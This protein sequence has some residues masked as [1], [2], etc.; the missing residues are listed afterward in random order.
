[1]SEL[2][3]QG[4]PAYSTVQISGKP[5]SVLIFAFRIPYLPDYLVDHTL[6]GETEQIK[7]KEV[8]N[9]F[10]RFV[11]SLRKYRNSAYSLRYSSDPD[12]GTIDVHLVCRFLVQPGSEIGAVEQY[13]QDISALLTSH[14]LPH[15]LIRDDSPAT[16]QKILVPSQG[17]NA[18]VE[19]RQHEAIVPLLS[20]DK[21]AYVIHPFWAASGEML[22]PFEVMLRQKK[23]VTLGIYLEP[24]ELAP[25]EQA[26]LSEAAYIAQTVSD[27]EAP[28]QS[29][30][31]I[32]RR[33]DPGAELVGRIYTEYLNSLEE[34]FVI[35]TQVIGHDPNA[36]WTVA[37]SFISSA[38]DKQRYDR[39]FA[40]N[41]SLPSNA[42]LWTPSDQLEYQKALSTFTNL[43]WIPWGSSKASA[44]K[45]RLPYLSGV[46]GA[47]AVFRF[48][49]S[50]RGGVP[51]IPVKQMAP[52]FEPGHR[53]AESSG[54][55][56][57]IGHLRRGGKAVVP[58]KALTRHALITGFTGSGKTNT[59]LFIL[60]QLW[61]KHK[62]PFL[63]IEAAKKEYRALSNVEGFKDLL[64]FTLGDETTSPFRHNPFELLEGIRLES[65][66]GRLQSCF[67]AAL[68][69]FGILPSIIGEAMEEIYKSKGW[70]LTDR[71]EHGDERLFP[72]MR[73]MFTAVI[74]IAENRGYAGETYH[75][76]RAAAAGRIGSLLRGS[77]GRM[78]GCQKSIPA[79][80][81]FT[82]PV[83]LELNDLNEDDKA[84][85]MMFLLT[86]MREYRET[87]PS[88][89]IQH[90]TV[91]EEAHNVL[92][93][94]QSVGNTEV[95]A[96]TK[97]K[98]V[99]SFSNIL[100]EV[101]A[102]GEG[103]LIADQSPEKLAPDAMRN[104]N[105]QIAHQL[106][107]QRDREAIARAMIMNDVQ[108]EF[109]AKLR[110]GEAALFQ[111]G[112]ERATFIMVPEF[113]DSAGFNK[114]PSDTDI[115]SFM[116]PF[117]EKFSKASLPFYGCR[118]CSA[119][120]I[121]RES[122]EPSTF[123]KERHEDLLSSLLEFENHP[124][125]E[126]WPKNW[127]SLT[128]VCAGASESVGY[129]GNLDAAYCFLA[130][131]IDFQ[132]TEHMRKM[133]EKTFNE[134]SKEG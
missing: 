111:T 90:L 105:L 32:R 19:I 73:D 51:G 117:Q 133:F 4:K 97:A 72:T 27:L 65:H 10:I 66:L 93:N 8:L 95:A 101:R 124:E 103:I 78:F 118:F 56:I 58:I 34:P 30:T 122:V 120:C 28:V 87:H 1:M 44:H 108:R 91:V 59:L 104:T 94:A 98:A 67:D 110:V 84:L 52:D 42:D 29:S 121:Y 24:T 41:Q 14:N 125:P 35:V 49:I 109:L 100:S 134:V 106:R 129:K 79:D 115:R 37:K 40:R 2:S 77:K 126:Y 21:D 50:I 92:S 83:I 102:Y 60:D 62:L 119:P 33:R 68:P 132:F 116:A 85:T 96:D 99:S 31:A 112:L 18:L 23:P 6:M 107:D 25:E 9:R 53:P 57:W 5:F 15:E 74:Q 12:N 11:G 130:Q 39:E 131:E 71:A 128:K 70:K 38:I 46:E 123:D 26:S 64:I 69:Q 76:I 7:L 113:K 88:S 17:Q 47:S 55:Q 22:E 54:E 114:V 63:V 61:K 43:Y 20:V 3:M 86:L 45:E 81:L 16:L 36:A 80:Q 75:N 89:S 48:P 13:W 82:R 127:H